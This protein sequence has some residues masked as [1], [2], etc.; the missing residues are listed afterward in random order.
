MTGKFCMLGSRLPVRPVIFNASKLGLIGPRVPAS[1]HGTYVEMYL[2]AL[3]PSAISI[4]N[5]SPE[6]SNVSRSVLI[7]PLSVSGALPSYARST[8]AFR[9]FISLEPSE[10]MI[11]AALS[12]L[13]KASC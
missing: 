7:P 5:A 11:P 3:P 2:L 10:R 6:S 1:S 4:K 12:L 8:I 13:S 9:A